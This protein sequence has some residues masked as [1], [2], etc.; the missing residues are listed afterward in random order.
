MMNI[1]NGGKHADNKRGHS[2]IHDRPV[3][4]ASFAEA[5]LYAPSPPSRPRRPPPPPPST[6]P[7]P[8]PP[9]L[10]TPQ[11]PPPPPLPTPPPPRTGPRLFPLAQ[12]GPEQEGIQHRGRGRRGFAPNLK[13]ER[14]SGRGHPGGDTE[15][16]TH[17]ARDVYIA[18][19]PAVEA[20]SSTTGNTS[21]QIGTSRPRVR[22][23]IVRFYENW[24][25]AIPIISI[26]DGMA[27]NDWDGLGN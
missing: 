27:E 17:R 6:P 15:A 2:G 25:R 4:G 14:G 16:G 24:G 22:N 20:S 3:A 9:P 11:P 26:E 13:S 1:L 5:L 21:S 8:R 23:Q 18:L 19:D 10:P 12:V 7:P